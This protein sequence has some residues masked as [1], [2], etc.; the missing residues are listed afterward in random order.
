MSSAFDQYQSGTP[1]DG[2][3]ADSNADSN[4]PTRDAVEAFPCGTLKVYFGSQTGTAEEFAETLVEEGRKFGF[5]ATKVDLEDFDGANL[6]R[7]ITHAW[8]MKH[9]GCLIVVAW[10]AM[11]AARNGPC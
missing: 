2:S 11:Q 1:A 3:S 9:T 10:E 6:K 4:A 8:H 7:E 5:D